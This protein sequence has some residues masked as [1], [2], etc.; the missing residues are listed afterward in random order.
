MPCAY[1]DGDEPATREHVWPKCL[2]D[3]VRSYSLRYVGR[4]HRIVN[5]DL[6][7]RDV[8]RDCNNGP[9]S[10]LDAYLCKLYDDY[11]IHEV[12]EGQSIVFRYDFNLLV[13]ALLKISYNSAR[14]TDVDATTL[15]RYAPVLLSQSASPVGTFVKVATIHTSRVLDDRGNRKVIP[16]RAFRTGPI[17]IANRNRRGLAARIVQIDGYRFYVITTEDV[18]DRQAAVRY[19]A[20]ERGTWLSRDGE[21]VIHEPTLSALAAFDGVQHWRT[22]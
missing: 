21:I 14:T 3:R 13:K 12:Q 6:T 15:R 17:V 10:L 1:C 4:V 18:L 20:S 19:L 2:I 5:T 22:P 8:C 16:A 7:V 9:L 11:L